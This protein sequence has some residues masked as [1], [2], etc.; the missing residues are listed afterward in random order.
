MDEQS[1]R[2]VIDDVRRGKLSRRA[3]TVR[4]IGPG[5]TAPLA[6]QMLAS[7]GV[8]ADQPEYKPTKP[9]GGGA[10]RVLW[11]QGRDI[12]RWQSP[13]YDK[14]FHDAESELDPARRAALFIA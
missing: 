1:L 6:A 2:D 11:W 10:L 8:A 3:L 13:E 12:T 14:L 4:T 7:S 5:L 9:G